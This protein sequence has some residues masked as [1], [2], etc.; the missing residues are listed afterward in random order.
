MT[1]LFLNNLSY[2]GQ[3]SAP[4]EILNGRILGLSRHA[5]LV[6]STSV[7]SL[8]L[9]SPAWSQNE[10]GLDAAGQGVNTCANASYIFP[11]GNSN[12]IAIGYLNSD[13]LTLDFTNPSTTIS[14]AT[15]TPFAGIFLS[16][17]N[18]LTVNA[19]NI[20]SITGFTRGIVVRHDGP[21]G[22]ATINVDGATIQSEASLNPGL[23]SFAAF[24]T[25]SAAS[26]ADGAITI[27]DSTIV[28][29][30]FR[31][32]VG[33]MINNAGTGGDATIVLNNTTIETRGVSSTAANSLI[34][35]MSSTGTA[36]LVMNGGS[37]LTAQGLAG[38]YSGGVIAQNLGL[39]DAYIEINNATINVRGSGNN[40]PGGNS[41]TL[42]LKGGVAAV[43]GN[44]YTSVPQ[45]RAST[46]TA[47]AVVNG[48]SVTVG[49]SIYANGIGA[50]NWAEGGS[51][52]EVT[53]TDVVTFGENA[54][55]IVAS[56][57]GNPS[58]VSDAVAVVI[59]G[60]VTTVGF[61]A[62]GVAGYSS[63][64]GGG[65]VEISGGAV[66]TVNGSGS[67]AASVRSRGQTI[68][69]IQGV[70]TTLTAVG[71]DSSGILSRQLIAGATSTFDVF[72][73]TEL[74]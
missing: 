32:S 10:C 58:N 18:N 38:T 37:V 2:A 56:T 57:Q 17:T 41:N 9:A 22:T 28:Q 62:A 3:K 39:G 43:I 4:V 16:G 74:L 27:T 31:G 55:G 12:G 59:G 29:N 65:R 51:L 42:S 6:L 50:V 52:A 72:V 14:A 64:T 11:T 13:G 61:N 21:T 33:V 40:I 34:S 48:G 68:V 47:R 71:Q 69:N 26:S 44:A 35:N 5:R 67:A 45:N 73:V 30:S 8:L 46:A 60:T 19:T 25:V 23:T 24:I 70:G 54:N 66:I 36:S 63:G 49:N 20:D 1:A 15:G 7:L 53:G